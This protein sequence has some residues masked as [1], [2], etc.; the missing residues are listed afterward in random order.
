MEQA[1]L[2]RESVE[3]LKILAD[4][5]AELVTKVTEEDGRA[6]GDVT[7]SLAQC[8]EYLYLHGPSPIRKIALGLSISVP[9][10]SQLVERLVGKELV[11]REHSEDDRRLARVELT[12]VGRKWIVQA[13]LS[14]MEWLRAILGM[15]TDERRSS[16]VDSLEEF[17][18]LALETN[19]HVDEACARCGIDHLAF[20]VV[21]QA[22][23]RVTGEPMEKY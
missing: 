9:A 7:P 18:K 1:A 21:G 13:R 22:H 5:F 3:Y 23:Q 6:N 17:I 4:V 14:R 10:V 2:T 15:M 19:G 12:D 11:T 16:L 20:C 8:L